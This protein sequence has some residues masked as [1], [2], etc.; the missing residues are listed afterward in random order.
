MAYPYAHIGGM[1]WLVTALRV[2]CRIVLFDVFDALSSP[3]EMARQ[4]AT[5]L[6]SAT[7]FFHAYL[8]AQRA[9]GSRPLFGRLRICMGGGAAIPADLD[10]VV[11]RELGGGGVANGYGLTEFPVAGYPPIDDA[12][13]KASSAWLPGPGVRARVVG[14]DDVDCAP[15]QTGELRLRGPQCF[16]GYLESGMDATAFDEQG[17]VKTGDLAVAGERGEITITGRLKEI[18]VRNGENISVAEVEA[19]LATHPAVAD[20][21]V[22]GLPDPQRGERCCAVV[23]TAT[24]AQPLTLADVKE[25]CRAAGLARYKTPEQLE[26]VPAIPRNAMGKVQRQLLREALAASSPVYLAGPAS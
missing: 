21:A 5:V 16:A 9:H 26:A 20:V 4:G 13:L 15:G 3:A 24:G 1:A 8:A 19:V 11:R 6:G 25:H 22:V 7:P 18:V 10:E 23:A 2:G 17:Y 12:T 14:A